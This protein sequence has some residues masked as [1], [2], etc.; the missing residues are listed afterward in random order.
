MWVDPTPSSDVEVRQGDLIGPMA[1][2]KLE[3]PFQVV[4]LPGSGD[5]EEGTPAVFQSQV[6]FFLVVGHCCV[7][8]QGEYVAL[9]PLRSTP[10]LSEEARAPYFSDPEEGDEYVFRA[11]ALDPIDGVVDPEGGRLIVADFERIASFRMSDQVVREKRVAAMTVEGRLR[12]RT[13]LGLF[14]ARPAPEDIA[15]LEALGLSP[16]L[17]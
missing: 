14:W 5:V 7:I 9:A 8:E 11:H 15:P 1:F 3:I 13:R 17:I 4:R 2:P 10:P 6:K 12:L 16:G